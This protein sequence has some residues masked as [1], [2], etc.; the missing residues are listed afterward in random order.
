MINTVFLLIFGILS[1]ILQTFFIYSILVFLN[2]VRIEKK[3]EKIYNRLE[4]IIE[5]VERAEIDAYKKIYFED[6]IVYQA[7]S[8]KLSKQDLQK[9]GDKFVKLVFDLCGTK[10]S[11]DLVFLFGYE[12]ICLKFKNSFIVRA[13]VDKVV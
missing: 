1:L 11:S 12:P 6:L 13:S 2:R 8:K 3:T 5:I 4:K 10:V 9:L 7:N